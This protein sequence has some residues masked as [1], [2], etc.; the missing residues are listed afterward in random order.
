MW[1]LQKGACTL[2]R[3]TVCTQGPDLEKDG[4]EHAARFV[5]R[6][7]KRQDRG[8]GY[9]ARMEVDGR[10]LP[11]LQSKDDAQTHLNVQLLD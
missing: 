2:L 3:P 9:M 10:P 8:D 1:E 11:R 5:A 6:A 4:V 7:G